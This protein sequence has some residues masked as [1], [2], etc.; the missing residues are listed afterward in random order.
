VARLIDPSY[1][2]FAA[3]NWYFMAVST[4]MVT[5]IG[6]LVTTYIEADFLIRI[7]LTGPLVFT[8]LLMLVGYASEVIQ[9]ANR[10]G[11][12][13]PNIITP[14]MSYFELILTWATRTTKHKPGN[15]EK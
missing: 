10:I 14:M 5:A 15:T 7:E 12:S 6:A 9:A 8:S 1:E 13:M 4:F 3:A 11:D 2:G